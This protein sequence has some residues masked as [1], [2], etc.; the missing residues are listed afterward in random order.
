MKNKPYVGE[1][2]EAPF[3]V[4]FDNAYFG[5]AGESP[6]PA[7]EEGEPIALEEPED[8]DPPA[9]PQPEDERP[10]DEPQDEPGDEPGDEP[11][12]GPG[13]EPQDEPGGEPQDEPGDEPQ[14]E[15]GNEP[16]DEPGDEPQDE[17]GDE[18]QDEPGDEPL[19]LDEPG[20]DVKSPLPPDTGTGFATDEPELLLAAGVIGAAMAAALGGT[21]LLPAKRKR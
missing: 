14:D 4:Y 1:D 11:Q 5:E 13:D 21:M 20:E 10:E 7:R 9:I 17:P 16:Q 18:P 2:W 6:A 3:A 19:E 8:L 12:D 15:P